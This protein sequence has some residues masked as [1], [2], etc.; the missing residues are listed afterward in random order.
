MRTADD[1]AAREAGTP[2]TGHHRH[3]PGSVV[4]RVG[5]VGARRGRDLRD[6]VHRVVGTPL[7][8]L[9]A[10]AIVV[11]EFCPAAARG[12]S[13]AVAVSHYRFTASVAT[14]FARPAGVPV[15]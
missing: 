9:P 1:R 12:S 11:L 3:V 6:L 4:F 14:Y 2:G 8:Q 13:D 7:L 5:P 10:R 15:L